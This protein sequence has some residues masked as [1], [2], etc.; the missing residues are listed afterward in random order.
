MEEA[1]QRDDC[2]PGNPGRG[3]DLAQ[4]CRTAAPHLPA[5]ERD[6]TEGEGCVPCVLSRPRAQPSPREDRSWSPR[7][8]HV[9]KTG[10]P[11]RPARWNQRQTSSHSGMHSALSSQGPAGQGQSLDLRA[12]RHHPRHWGQP[13]EADPGGGDAEAKA[14]NT[15]PW[16]KLCLKADRLCQPFPISRARAGLLPLTTKASQRGNGLDSG[17]QFCWPS[18]T[19][20]EMRPHAPLPSI[21]K[22]LTLGNKGAPGEPAQGS[23]ASRP[24][25]RPARS[26]GGSR[27]P[28]RHRNPCAPLQPP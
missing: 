19:L 14:D 4:T 8:H 11:A 18:H 7:L 2:S 20:P 10:P 24:E 6:E 27:E 17:P 26:V 9:I 23:R 5:R 1:P 12:R 3:T 22:R 15:D 13:R 25:L 21:A 16:I 28:N